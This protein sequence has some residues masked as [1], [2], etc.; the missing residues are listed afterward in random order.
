M[1]ALREAGLVIVLAILST[2]GLFA[3]MAS[4]GVLPVMV[5]KE[6]TAK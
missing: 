6:W 2:I 5:I 1:T 3:L 4:F